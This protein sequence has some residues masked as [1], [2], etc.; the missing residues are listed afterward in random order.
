MHVDCAF[1]LIPKTCKP[2]AYFIPCLPMFGVLRVMQVPT[3]SASSGRISS[4]VGA[5]AGVPHKE[6][7]CSSFTAT[8]TSSTRNHVTHKMLSGYLHLL[9]VPKGVQASR[10]A[11]RLKDRAGPIAPNRKAP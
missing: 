8:N 3:V 4:T 6:E 11:K 9:L 10:K 2:F 1:L 5:H 7:A